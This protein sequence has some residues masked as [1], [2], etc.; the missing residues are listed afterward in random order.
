MKKVHSE[1]YCFNTEESHHIHP[2][3]D[4]ACILSTPKLTG[5]TGRFV[6]EFSKSELGALVEKEQAVLK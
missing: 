3:E 2:L 4:I 5:P 1:F 6:Y